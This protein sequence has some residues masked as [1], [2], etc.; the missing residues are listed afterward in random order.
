MVERYR[1]S[2]GIEFAPLKDEVILF[3]SSSSKFCVLNRTSSFIWSQLSQPASREEIAQRLGASFSGVNPS[4]AL[5]DVDSTLQELLALE[6]IVPIDSQTEL[7]LGVK[8]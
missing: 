8:P 6:L 4:Q 7:P 2:A 1:Q 5:S 3:H